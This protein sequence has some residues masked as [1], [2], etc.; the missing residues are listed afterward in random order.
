MFENSTC[1]I[2]CK[3]VNIKRTWGHSNTQ[4]S[5]IDHIPSAPKF[6][7]SYVCSWWNQWNQS[8]FSWE[9]LEVFHLEMTN[10]CRIRL[11]LQG[12]LQALWPAHYFTRKWTCLLAKLARS[13][14]SVK[15]VGLAISHSDRYH[16]VNERACSIL[17]TWLGH[18]GL[19]TVVRMK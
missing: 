12:S 18:D 14:S 5:I 19:W 6:Q 9:C 11:C 16:Y 3:N 8:L 17:C 1:T 13:F 15:P 10:V 7:I 4:G 2:M